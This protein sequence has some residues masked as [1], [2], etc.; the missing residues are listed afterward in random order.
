M[1]KTADGTFYEAT[2][3]V[4]KC[5]TLLIGAGD[6]NFETEATPTNFKLSNSTTTDFQV[7]PNPSTGEMMADLSPFVGSRVELSV[8]GI[9]GKLIA[10]RE[11]EEAKDEAIDLSELATN[12]SNGVYF[13]EIRAN[14]GQR[15][16][17]KWML[18]R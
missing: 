12:W 8:F 13:V 15:F 4:N 11:I 17:S 18:Q 10:R 7:F 6:D 5:A 9:S 3:S 14:D 1:V 16:T 2:L